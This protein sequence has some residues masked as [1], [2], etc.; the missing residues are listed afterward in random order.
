MQVIIT[1]Y[2]Q[3][4]Y[5]S[6]LFKG[7]LSFVTSFSPFSGLV[8]SG[9]RIALVSGGFPRKTKTPADAPTS[10][11]CPCLIA[12]Q[13]F[14]ETGKLQAKLPSQPDFRGYG[15]PLLTDVHTPARTMI[16]LDAHSIPVGSHFL[17]KS[18]VVRDTPA[19]LGTYQSTE[20][21]NPALQQPV[22]GDSSP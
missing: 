9:S 2:R 1:L 20:T 10:G 12:W 21:K 7:R 19:L 6:T 18:E 22:L 4:G 5:L 3:H 14:W 17:Q 8:I 11:G 16:V 13:S 15:F